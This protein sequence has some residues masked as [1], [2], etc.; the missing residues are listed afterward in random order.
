MNISFKLINKLDFLVS[1]FFNKEEKNHVGTRIFNCWH[2]YFRQNLPG[3][4]C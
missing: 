2:R 1:V 4:R 3:A